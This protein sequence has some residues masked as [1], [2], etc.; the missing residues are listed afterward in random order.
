MFFLKFLLQD[1]NL[2][3]PEELMGAVAKFMNEFVYWVT[4]IKDWVASFNAR[5][6]YYFAQ[7]GWEIGNG[8]GLV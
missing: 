7:L 1:T 5:K 6:E 8:K 2:N 3:S 4:N